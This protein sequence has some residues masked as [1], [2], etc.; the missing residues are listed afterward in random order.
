MHTNWGRTRIVTYSFIIRNIS[1]TYSENCHIGSDQQV[2][3]HGQAWDNRLYS[4]VT[5]L[6]YYERV[7]LLPGYLKLKCE[8]P[9]W[10]LALRLLS[11]AIKLRKE[12]TDRFK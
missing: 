11:H 4:E 3:P 5:F 8:R 2:S 1:V 9:M 12:E 7:A 10:I 6:I